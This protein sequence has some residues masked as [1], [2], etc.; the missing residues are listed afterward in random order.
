MITPEYLNQIVHATEETVSVLHTYLIG[1][2]A[3]HIAS[4][5]GAA[6]EGF[7]MPSNIKQMHKMMESGKVYEDIQ[8][9]LTKKYPV[10]QEEIEQA[11]L[12]SAAEISKANTEF[13]K[14]IVKAEDLDIKVPDYDINGIP[15]TAK[16]LNLTDHEVRL[17]EADYRRTNGTVKN[18]TKTT[19]DAAQTTFIEA[20]DS[21][22]V[23]AQH[24][25]SPTQAITEAIMEMADKG[26]GV[27]L[28]GNQRTNIEV[29][30]ARAVRTG[31]NQANAHIVLQ[32]CAELGVSW[33]KVSEHLG[34]RVTDKND[35]TNHSWWQG[36]VYS[37]DWSSPELAD[38]RTEA[39]GH[40]KEIADAIGEVKEE[41]PDF[42]KTTGY[43]DILG[44]C[45]VNCRHTFS[46]FYPN[47]Q[48]DPEPT[49]DKEA[50]AKRYSEQQRQRALERDIRKTK[51]EIAAL[52]GSG[53]THIP[54]VQGQLE[55]AKAKLKVQIQKYYDYCKAHRLNADGSRM[56]VSK[57][58]D[59]SKESVD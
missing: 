36:K 3:N 11:F 58:N 51:R 35:Y 40:I 5:F 48:P 49:I 42:V 16:D 15:K 32:R 28:Y 29:A 33:V 1:R 27:V 26:V 50:N 22:M 7:L 12:N 45:G 47:I 6:E 10:I 24:G 59:I 9:E 14:D 20:C 52:E 55:D 18:L 17:L 44:L 53:L 13:E 41:Y 23:K 31:V 38:Y 34:A 56:I 57:G 25:V 19:A 37:L 54:D 39:E 30:I 4:F 43:G 46:A 8:K 21:A 2:I